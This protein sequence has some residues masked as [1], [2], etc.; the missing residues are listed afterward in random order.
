MPA[1]KGPIWDH[2]YVGLKQNTSH[3]RAHCHGYDDPMPDDGELESSGGDFE[4]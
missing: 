4:G 1:S 3:S 2:F